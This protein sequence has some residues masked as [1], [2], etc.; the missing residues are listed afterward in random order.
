MQLDW[1][2]AIT[3]QKSTINSAWIKKGWK[4]SWYAKLALSQS[5]Y[6]MLKS[7]SCLEREP[8]FTL[9]QF[10]LQFVAACV[11]E[12]PCSACRQDELEEQASQTRAARS[13]R[14]GLKWSRNNL[15]SLIREFGSRLVG[16]LDA[17]VWS[18]WDMQKE[19]PKAI[20]AGGTD[21]NAPHDLRTDS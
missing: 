13:T 3:L 9:I 12:Q 8:V 18:Y 11:G 1:R 15:Q 14:N 16:V 5:Y 21:E 4:D 19:R 20:C 2:A 6:N 17:E 10:R 7:F